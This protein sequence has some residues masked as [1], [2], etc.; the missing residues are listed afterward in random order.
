MEIKLAPLHETHYF[1]QLLAGRGRSL[2][3][4]GRLLFFRKSRVGA[5]FNLHFIII[6]RI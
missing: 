2:R 5:N 1:K 4:N 6:T 3:E